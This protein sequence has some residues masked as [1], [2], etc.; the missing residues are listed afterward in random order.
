MGSTDLD[1]KDSRGLLGTD[2]LKGF[3]ASLVHSP[4]LSGGWGATGTQNEANGQI[5]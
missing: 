1:S 2:F 3:P 4:I 5:K